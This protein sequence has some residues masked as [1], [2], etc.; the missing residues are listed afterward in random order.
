MECVGKKRASMKTG[1][2]SAIVR[3]A[4]L[5]AEQENWQKIT[6]AVGLVLDFEPV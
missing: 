2:S 5:R 3:Q 1:N 4:Q 6:S